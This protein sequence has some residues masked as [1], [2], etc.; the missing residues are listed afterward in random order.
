M[1]NALDIFFTRPTALVLKKSCRDNVSLPVH[2]NAPNFASNKKKL[3]DLRSALDE[4]SPPDAHLRT[5]VTFRFPRTNSHRVVRRP[6][7]ILCREVSGQ[8]LL[9][10]DV[11]AYPRD[12]LYNF[13]FVATI[14]KLDISNRRNNLSKTNYKYTFALFERFTKLHE[15]EEGICALLSAF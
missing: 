2:T 9:R 10:S 13:S 4:W 11:L 14:G 3:F 8:C 1:R 7:S 15:C 6:T 5:L 12:F